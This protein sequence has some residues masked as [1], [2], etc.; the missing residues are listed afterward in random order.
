MQNETEQGDIVRVSE[1]P[2]KSRKFQFICKTYKIN[3][4]IS[5]GTLG[6]RIFMSYLGNRASIDA[7]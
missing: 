1:M 3:K 5:L 4:N 2:A 6:Y 7:V